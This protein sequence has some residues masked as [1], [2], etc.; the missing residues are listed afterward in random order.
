MIVYEV[1]G[2]NSITY[3]SYGSYV[4]REDAELKKRIMM[5]H[6]PTVNIVEVEIEDNPPAAETLFSAEGCISDSG[7]VTKIRFFP[8]DDDEPT[9]EVKFTVFY[10][11]SIGF[12]LYATYNTSIDPDEFKKQV[13]DR[14]EEE[15]RR[16]N[17]G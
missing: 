5:V 15:F 2:D 14:V 6:M 7:K 3:T 4:N 17:N 16:N 9:D 11:Q 13:T 12:E 10:D 1:W 8:R